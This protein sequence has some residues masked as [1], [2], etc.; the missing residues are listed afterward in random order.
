MITVRNLP[1][2]FVFLGRLRQVLAA[3]MHLVVHVVVPGGKSHC[4]H[5]TDN[6][7]YRD[8]MRREFLPLVLTNIGLLSG[9]LLATCQ[10]LFIQSRNP[11]Y[12]QLAIQYKVVCLGH[13]NHAIPCEANF[14]ADATVIQ[15]LLLA[16]DDVSC[17]HN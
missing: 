4:E 10:S 12:E 3:N 17:S 13:M 14:I 1:A 6:P 11:V 2:I 16:S 8:G 9:A 7:I 5:F 15:A